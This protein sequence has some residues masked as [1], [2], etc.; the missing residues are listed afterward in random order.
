M[1]CP[2]WQ[3]ELDPVAPEAVPIFQAES[4]DEGA[5]VSAARNLGSYFCARS[6]RELV[7]REND[8]SAVGVRVRVRVCARE[9]GPGVCCVCERGPGVT[10]TGP[11]CVC[12]CEREDQACVCV[13]ERGD[14]ARVC[15]C[16]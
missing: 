10:T 4:P 12:V 7:V 5:F 11:R 16:V 15:V 14:Q 2:H 1:R 3:V 13:C 9:R 6:M 8:W